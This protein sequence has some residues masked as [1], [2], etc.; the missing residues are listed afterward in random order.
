MS[1]QCT[2]CGSQ[3]REGA[4][5]CHACGT[6]VATTNLP[7]TMKMEPPKTVE[8]SI[9]AP[10][11]VAEPH[12]SAPRFN[13][14]VEPQSAPSAYLPQ[15]PQTYH[16]Q[17]HLQPPKKK[18]GALKYVLIS[19]AIIIFL[20]A[21]SI[22]GAVYVVGQKFQQIA[23]NAQAKGTIPLPQGFPEISIGENAA[24]KLG[25]PIYPNAKREDF[26]IAIKG[27]GELGD[28]SAGTAIFSTEDDVD[29]VVKFY[30]D[31]YGEKARTTDIKS[32]G[33][34]TVEIKIDEGTGGKHIVITEG[35]DKNQIIIAGGNGPA[36]D[37]VN[38]K[39]GKAAKQMEKLGKEQAKQMKEQA[40]RMKRDTERMKQELERGLSDAPPPPPPP[41][42]PL[43]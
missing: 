12:T 31:H 27:N 42:K 28:Y 35:E 21:A 29:E 24:N 8:D 20:G 3:T 16:Q 37:A 36:S 41:A 38:D 7:L 39:T 5:F 22:I 9:P 43:R 33:K 30:Q 13:P 11:P 15:A 26:A 14:P 32:N 10:P 2:S 18:S 17:S 34:R 6:P 4:K 1:D 25:V 23:K 40:D 19:L